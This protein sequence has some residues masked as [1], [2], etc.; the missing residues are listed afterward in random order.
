MHCSCD[1]AEQLLEISAAIVA[2]KPEGIHSVW[3]G[4]AGDKLNALI[5]ERAD[6]DNPANRFVE[7]MTSDIGTKRRKAMAKLVSSKQ[8]LRELREE[9][10]TA[11]DK[12]IKNQKWTVTIDPPE[13]DLPVLNGG[14]TWTVAKK[15]GKKLGRTDIRQL[16]S[17]LYQ[18]QQTAK[19]ALKK[20]KKAE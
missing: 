10:K 12:S 11:S 1:T 2:K 17:D 14:I 9:L 3:I 8:R 20:A 4:N 16:R 13:S 6:L 15:W 7:T 19:S 18:R 5:A